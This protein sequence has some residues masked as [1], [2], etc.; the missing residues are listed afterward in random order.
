MNFL[1]HAHLSFNNPEL[2]VGN[3]IS[4]FVKGKSKYDYPK[5][6]QNGIELH[7]A[8]DTFTD[9]HISTKNARQY[10]KDAVGAYSGAFVDVSFDHFLA[11]DTKEFNEASLMAFCNDTYTTLTKYV[12][13]L[14]IRFANMIPFMVSDNW[15]FNYSKIWGIKRSFEGLTRR[16]KYLNDSIAAFE[17]FNNH[18]YPLQKCY[19]EFFPMLKEFARAYAQNLNQ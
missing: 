11:T 6:I 7:R 14:P 1:A 5:G 19:I 2:L 9:S 17:S 13:I 12:H 10:F 3:M 8:I 16:A 15:L 4:D 18:Y